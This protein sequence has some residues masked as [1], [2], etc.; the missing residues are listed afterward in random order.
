MSALTIENLTKTFDHSRALDGLS[1]DI[2]DG[3]FFVVLGP[4][5]A[6]KTTL[7]RTIAGLTKPDKGKLRLDGFD[8]GDMPP[9]QRDVAM[10]FQQ[11]SLY[12]NLTVR[13]NL[14][15]P[16]KAPG[17]DFT[18]TEIE[19]KIART[20]SVLKI[21]HRLDV[22]TQTLSGGEMQRVALGRAL[23]RSPRLFLMDEPLSN[24]DAKLR[25][26]LRLE[27][28]ALQRDLGAT[29]VLVTHDQTEALS[30]GDRIAVIN[31]G[32]LEQIGT[33]DEIYHS[34]VNTFVAGLV[35]N[36]R[37]N[38]FSDAQ[39][40]GLFESLPAN[41]P[42]N[43][44]LGLRPE[45]LLVTPGGNTPLASIEYLGAEQIL[46]F[47]HDGKLIKASVSSNSRYDTGK[48]YQLH[49]NL[50]NYHLFDAKDG[51]RRYLPEQN[52]SQSPAQR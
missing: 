19:K 15:F 3:E 13:E 40:K 39:A 24:L 29:I 44:L 9:A 14:A 1:L 52:N 35:G 11:Y 32:T 37:I 20:A 23:V 51:Q 41:I 33:P 47:E 46:A 31:N 49:A 5:G 22:R 10:V 45:H 21:E 2:K 42:E 4:T 27:L 12:P 30:L 28:R 43:T 26:S 48:H 16:L 18:E 6:G 50:N 38:F 25:E 8:I 17:R 34:P 7:L 36:P